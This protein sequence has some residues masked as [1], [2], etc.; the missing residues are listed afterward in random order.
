MKAS[1]GAHRLRGVATA[2]A[3]IPDGVAMTPV[4]KVDRRQEGGRGLGCA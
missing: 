1:G 4:A 2:A 3:S